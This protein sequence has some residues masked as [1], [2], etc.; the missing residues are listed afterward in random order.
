MGYNLNLKEVMVRY[1]I[2]MLIIIIGGL[3][4]NIWIMLLGMPVFLTAILG[5]CPIYQVLG[6]NHAEKH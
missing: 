3:M 6:I 1:A 4:G 5:W 2:M